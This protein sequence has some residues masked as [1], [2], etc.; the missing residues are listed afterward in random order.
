MSLVKIVGTKSFSR[1]IPVTQVVSD[2]AEPR[3]LQT[4]PGLSSTFLV[5]F[6]STHRENDF[7]RIDARTGKAIPWL[8]HKAFVKFDRRHGTLCYRRR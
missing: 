4:V 6:E 8:M 3:L 1:P 2:A 7:Y 5:G